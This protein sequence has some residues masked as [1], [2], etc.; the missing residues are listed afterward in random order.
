MNFWENAVDGVAPNIN[1]L[2]NKAPA[3]KE[4]RLQEIIDYYISEGY[5]QSD[6]VILTCK[7][8]ERSFMGDKVYND[9]YQYGSRQLTLT[10][11]R[12]FKG[13]EAAVIILIDIDKSI[14]LE[15]ARETKRIF[16]VGTS[17]ARHHL[18]IFSE[19]SE[20]DCIEVLYEKT[21]DTYKKPDKAI[22][23]LLSACLVKRI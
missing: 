14:L 2:D 9:V 18:E 5:K 16:Y 6:I 12:K 17:R 10:T 7:T 19:L 4:K 13:L 1:I 20:R 23:N 15:N 21:E 22:A 3:E 11:C 8:L